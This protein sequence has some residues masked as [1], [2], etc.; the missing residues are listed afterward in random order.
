MRHFI[1]IESKSNDLTSV[2][3][4][5][6]FEL[7]EDQVK[8]INKILAPK[9]KKP[10]A[11]KLPYYDLGNEDFDEDEL[12][13]I[14]TEDDE[15]DDV[16]GLNKL[17]REHGYVSWDSEDYGQDKKPSRLWINNKYWVEFIVASGDC[18]EATWSHRIWEGEALDLTL[19]EVKK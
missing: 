3:D 12:E 16:D 7:D 13:G 8:K 4:V 18:L 10:K 11:P 2:L 15:L 5:Q 6:T 14:F 1:K 17:L 9:E 19:I